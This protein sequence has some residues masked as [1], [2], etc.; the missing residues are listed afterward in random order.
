MKVGRECK[1]WV[2]KGKREF[3]RKSYKECQ[4]SLLSV[5]LILERVKHTREYFTAM[6]LTGD[7]KMTLLHT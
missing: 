7:A 4:L 1:E 5:S 2:G 6:V 3:K